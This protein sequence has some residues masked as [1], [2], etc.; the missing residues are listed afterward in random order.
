MARAANSWRID[1]SEPGRS[2]RWNTTIVVLS[3]PVGAGTPPRVTATKRVSLPRWSS[4]SSASTSSPLT[5]PARDVPMA[6]D[7]PSASPATIC[8]ASAVELAG[9]CSTRGSC[10]RRKPRHWAVAT[11]IDT[12]RS[13]S[14]MAT[15]GGASRHMTMGMTTSRC[16]RSSWSKMRAS[17]VML[18]EPSMA[19]S[20]GTKP[21]STSP[22]VTAWRT[23]VMVPQGTSSIAA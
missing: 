1:R 3:W 17:R 9:T 5:L 15:P 13:M 21:I 2:A 14:P 4:M 18:T 19:F 11:G 6:A 22:D 10:S 23:S 16:M 12:M 7:R 20:I 8:A